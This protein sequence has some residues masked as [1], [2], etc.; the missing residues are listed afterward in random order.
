MLG[1]VL[2][3]AAALAAAPIPPSPVRWVEDHAGMIS[4]AARAALDVR[5]EAYEHATGHQVVVWIGKTLQGAPLDDWAV[6]TFAAWQLGRKG[7][8]DGIALFVLADD[9]KIDIEVGYGLEDKV[10]DATASRIIRD[11][12]APRL[13]AGDRDGAVTAGADAILAAIEGRPWAGAAGGPVRPPDKAPSPIT[14]ILGGLGAV[15]ALIL[16]V[17]YPRLAFWILWSIV[18]G[19]RRNGDSSGGGDFGGGGGRSGGGGARGGW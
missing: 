16:L 14:L 9:R 3:V 5:L 8:D 6:R 17:K 18:V 10:P 2:A 1:P 11:V 4:P 19:G 15:L 7:K 13:R 12:M